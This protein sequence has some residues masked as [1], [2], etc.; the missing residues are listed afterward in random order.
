[1]STE[2]MNPQR[3]LLVAAVMATVGFAILMSKPLPSELP[4]RRSVGVLSLIR[5]PQ[6]GPAW[7]ELGE[8]RADQ[9]RALLGIHSLH[10]EVRIIPDPCIEIVWSVERGRKQEARLLWNGR[11]FRYQPTK[12]DTHETLLTPKPVTDLTLIESDPA[13]TLFERGF[14][15]EWTSRRPAWNPSSPLDRMIQQ[16]SE[17]LEAESWSEFFGEV[18]SVFGSRLGLELI[19]AYPGG[20]FSSRHRLWP[21]RLTEVFY[22]RSPKA[23]SALHRSSRY[24]GGDRSARSISHSN[25]IDGTNGVER[26]EFNALFTGTHGWQETVQRWVLEDLRRQRVPWDAQEGTLPTENNEQRSIQK[27]TDEGVAR[28]DFTAS[29]DGVFLHFGEF[30]TYSH[31]GERLANHH[32]KRDYVVLLPWKILAPW[33]RP[34]VVEAF[35][36]TPAV[37]SSTLQEMSATDRPESLTER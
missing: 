32:G 15:V 3:W 8:T 36:M 34:E 2:M 24:L 22:H 1:M 19:E 11:Q 9:T 4:S 33:V 14:V 31:F 13:P 29:V 27:L 18:R 5:L 30:A 20:N 35:T 6:A 17:R 12:G 37:P 25:F 10:P 23:V 16:V 28:L 21:A 7:V 26:L